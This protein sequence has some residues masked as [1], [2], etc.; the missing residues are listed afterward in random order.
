MKPIDAKPLK[1][2]LLSYRSNPHCGGQ[3]VYIKNLSHA[4]KQLGHEVDVVAGPP[5][6]ELDANIPLFMLKGLDLYNPSNMYQMPPFKKLWDP[7]N[8]MEWLSTSSMGYPEPFIFGIR[9][10]RY[11]KNKFHHYDIIHDNQ[12]L[13]YGLLNMNKHLPTIVTIHHPI[14]K[15]REIAVNSVTATWKKMQYM[16]WYSFLHM[17]KRVARRLKTI[18]T[19]SEC[20]RKDIAKDFS[21][22]EDR[23]RV[24]PNGID[25]TLFRP[26]PDIKR[27]KNHL[28]V[29]NSADSALKGLYYLLHAIHDLS[30]KR[31][32]RLTVI[33][34]PKK[35]GGVEKLI[36]NLNIQN[37]ITFTGRISNDAFIQH[38]AKSSIAVVPSLYEGFGLPV[39]EAMACKVPVI[40]T[41]GG[42][43]PEVAGNAA[44]LVPPADSGALSKAISYLLDNPEQAEKIGA[45]GYKRVHH[46]F[47]WDMAAQKTADIYR[48]VIRGNRRF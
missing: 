39:G 7:V 11:L 1:I 42:A 23:I 35:N 16:R 19:V 27:E 8:L 18:I 17:Q 48:E 25:T 31:D 45:A 26:M 30:L 38:Y 4:L 5:A 6:P 2:C 43:L 37:L 47:S 21:I 14:T 46:L 44:V 33:G 32:I 13:S 10:Y 20:S 34:T 24:V 15:D 12:S 3:G 29:T 22:P 9:A 28:I 40:C 41:T 36:Q